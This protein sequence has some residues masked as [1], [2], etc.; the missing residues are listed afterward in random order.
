LKSL[1]QYFEKYC[2]LYGGLK[3]WISGFTWSTIHTELGGAN[4]EIGLKFLQK[5][6]QKGKVNAYFA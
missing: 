3:R 4:N 1:F 5:R 6:T 2:F